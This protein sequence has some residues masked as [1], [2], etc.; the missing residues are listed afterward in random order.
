MASRCRLRTGYPHEDL[1]QTALLVMFR[2][3]ERASYDP[4][5]GT[6]STY[7]STAIWHEFDAMLQKTWFPVTYPQNRGSQKK[8]LTPPTREVLGVPDIRV[9]RH[10]SPDDIASR[11]EDRTRVRDALGRLSAYDRNL[12]MMVY[13]IGRRARSQSQIRSRKNSSYKHMAAT[14]F[15]N[16]VRRA[17]RRLLARLVE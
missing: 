15:R 10:A 6:V 7:L 12:L 3:F 2:C 8:I 16:K 5:K 9:S 13:G 4:K 1:V 14:T 11:N 17:E